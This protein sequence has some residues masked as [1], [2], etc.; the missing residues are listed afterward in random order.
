MKISWRAITVLVLLAGFFLHPG[1]AGA[2]DAASAAAAAAAVK[3]VK[4]ALG[5]SVYL[6]GGYTLNMATPEPHTNAL[7]VFDQ[8]DNSMS[9]DLAELVF[10]KAAPVTGGLGWHL[11]LSAGETAKYI[12]STGFGDTAGNDPYDLT[13][14]YVT[15][16]APVGKGVSFTFGKFATFLGAEVIEAG[17]DW[18]YSRS[19]LFNYAI[20]FTN[21]GLKIAYPVCDQ[22]QPAVYIVNGWDNSEANST[23]KSYG[24][25]ATINPV[26]PLSIVA[27]YL[28]GPETDFYNLNYDSN[29][30]IYDVTA[31]YK[32]TKDLTFMANYDYG[33]QD[34]ARGDAMPSAKWQGA[35]GYARY[36]ATDKIA[37]ALRG[38][39]FD[40]HDGVRTGTAQT[41]YEVTFTPEFNVY[42]MLVRPEY[43]HDWSDQPVFGAAKD[44][45]S[46]DT[47]ALGLIF[48]F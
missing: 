43:R 15:A 24:F 44:K 30:S 48:N 40:D 45:K 14:A 20:P 13:E 36:Q 33:D 47:V 8:A 26:A 17:G 31:T 1:P 34:S 10:D 22:F 18:N 4:D 6:Q 25:S 41:D 16:L 19:L 38:E 12:H 46:Q 35:A 29:R 21:T 9:L 11:K 32:A 39:W 27:N 3:Q 42:G 7:R 28:Y 37:F 2:D 23:G 5:L